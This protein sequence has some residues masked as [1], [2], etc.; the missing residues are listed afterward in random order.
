MYNHTLSLYHLHGYAI[1]F[2]LFIYYYFFNEIFFNEHVHQNKNLN[3]I[4]RS[5]ERVGGKVHKTDAAF[6][7]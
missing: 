2:Y 7:L 6:P 1:H 4:E 5:G 3:I